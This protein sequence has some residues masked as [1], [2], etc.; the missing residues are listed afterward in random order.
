MR[1]SGRFEGS[2]R[3]ESI[4]LTGDNKKGDSVV[5]MIVA[6]YLY[7]YTHQPTEVRVGSDLT[8]L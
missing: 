3:D 8:F 1:R 5:T 4:P 7:L 2:I 6:L